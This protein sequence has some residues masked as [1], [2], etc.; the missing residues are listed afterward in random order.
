M[1]NAFVDMMIAMLMC[2]LMMFIAKMLGLSDFSVGFSSC[3]GYYLGLSLS[4]YL[5]KL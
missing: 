2:I 4:K 3:Y 1:K 5:N